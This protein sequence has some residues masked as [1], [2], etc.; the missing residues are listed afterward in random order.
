M[1][2]RKLVIQPIGLE[3]L[4]YWATNN[5]RIVKRILELIDNIDDSP[6]EGKGK[7]ELLKHNLKG[8]WSRRIDQE[9]RLVYEVN[10]TQ[11][12]VHACKGHYE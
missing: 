7:P 10:D 5:P 9:H 8:K 1:V 11:I 12:I 4:Q 2:K 3:H 6:F